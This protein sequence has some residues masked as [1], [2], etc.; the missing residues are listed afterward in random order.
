VPQFGQ[1]VVLLGAARGCHQCI[2]NAYGDARQIDIPLQ[3]FSKQSQ[4][5]ASIPVWAALFWFKLRI[6]RLMAGKAA[7]DQAWAEAARRCRLSPDEVRMA[8]ELGIMPR[9]LLKNV[10]SPQQPWKGPVAEWVREL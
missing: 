9:S 5:W 1:G 4:H 3:H 7:M 8:K 2:T 6:E 10:P